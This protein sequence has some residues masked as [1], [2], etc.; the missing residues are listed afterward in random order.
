[1]VE[2]TKL[3]VEVGSRLEDIVWVSCAPALGAIAQG[4]DKAY[5]ISRV[6][7]RVRATCKHYCALGHAI[8]VEDDIQAALESFPQ[9]STFKCTMQY[10]T[11][12]GLGVEHN[13]TC[14]K[15]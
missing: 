8:P 5:T 3:L 9:R 12:T 4:K 10:V 2:E 14:Q 1:M 15:T 6:L 13:V 11:E 7:A